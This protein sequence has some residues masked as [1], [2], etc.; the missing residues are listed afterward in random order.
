MGKRMMSLMLAALLLMLTVSGAL[1][2]DSH[3][4]CCGEGVSWELCGDILTISGSGEMRDFEHDGAS[5]RTV[6]QNISRVVVD[7]GVTRIGENAFAGCSAL[8]SIVLPVSLTY[9]AAGAFDGC[10]SLE[11]IYYGGSLRQ[12]KENVSGLSDGMNNAK[13]YFGDSSDPFTDID[14]WYHDNIIACYAAGIVSG[15]TDGTFRPN[16]DVTRAQFIMMLYNLCGRPSVSGYIGFA[17]ANRID[18]CYKDAVRFGAA[19]NIIKGYEDNTF[20]PDE[21]LNRAQMA[22]FAYRMLC[23]A[24]GEEIDDSLKQPNMSFTDGA[25]ILPCYE[26]AV[27]VMSNIGVING[28]PDGS[29]DP[30]AAATRAESATVLLRL[31]TVF[32]QIT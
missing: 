24:A 5:W 3:N 13:I 32:G 21:K 29:F 19:M 18:D 10:T 7:D 15:H 22:T 30:D 12:W 9:I 6:K 26:E 1:A 2:D 23:A 8:R 20:R 28:Y 25:A 27:T 4:G 31:R 16:E 11:S 14:D 17:D